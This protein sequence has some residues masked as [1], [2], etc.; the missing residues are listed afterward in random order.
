MIEAPISL[1]HLKTL[2]FVKHHKDMCSIHRNSPKKCLEIGFDE[3]K[4]GAAFL[5]RAV[6]AG[7]DLS[8]MNSHFVEE[9]KGNEKPSTELQ[10]IYDEFAFMLTRKVDFSGTLTEES[11]ESFAVM[12]AIMSAY[13]FGAKDDAKLLCAMFEND[14]SFANVAAKILA[15]VVGLKEWGKLVSS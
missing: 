11:G 5:T 1:S 7:I 9:I 10:F 8:Q 4:G 13:T 14:T 15:K 12:R 6:V 3:S 2:N